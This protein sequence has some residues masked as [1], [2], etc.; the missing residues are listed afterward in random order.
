MSRGLVE[1]GNENADEGLLV[2]PGISSGP[3]G[4]PFDEVVEEMSEYCRVVRVDTWDDA[5]DL[6]ELTLKDLHQQ[7]DEAIN[8]LTESGCERIHVI[9]KSFGGQ[10]ALTYPDNVSFSSMVLWAPAVGLGTSNV[11]KWRSTTLGHASTATDITID[12][13]TLQQLPAET[14]LIHGEQDQIVEVENSETI[15][16]NIQGADVRVLKDTGHSFQG[17]KDEVIENTLDFLSQATSSSR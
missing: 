15:A 5:R 11:E 8:R 14:L 17:S 7:I 3:F 6:E 10:L 4:S 16:E 9:G 12:T 2:I 1:E 13:S